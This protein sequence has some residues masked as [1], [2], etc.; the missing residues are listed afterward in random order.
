[1]VPA[2]SATNKHHFG[3]RYSILPAGS[4]LLPCLA[5][6]N[7]LFVATFSTSIFQREVPVLETGS[8]AALQ[9]HSPVLPLATSIPQPE[10]LNPDPWPPWC[11]CRCLPNSRDNPKFLKASPCW[12]SVWRDK[13]G[14]GDWTSPHCNRWERL[15][16]PC[17]KRHKIIKCIHR[18]CRGAAWPHYPAQTTPCKRWE[19]QQLCTLSPQGCAVPGF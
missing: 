4:C 11:W 10:Q 3:V 7:E 16:F 18:R 19:A 8:S 14:F 13:M 6:A 9:V 15:N 5:G 17:S 1:M 2:L 12:A